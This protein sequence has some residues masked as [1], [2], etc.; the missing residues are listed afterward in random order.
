MRNSFTEPCE[1]ALTPALYSGQLGHRGAIDHG[2]IAVSQLD[3]V[4]PVLQSRT[5]GRLNR[6][7]DPVRRELWRAFQRGSLS[8][9][10]FGSTL[11]RLD[12]IGIHLIPPPSASLPDGA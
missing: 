9:A 11:Y 5:R 1:S 7:I 2:G 12:E 8:E 10:E 3:D 6:K 4:F